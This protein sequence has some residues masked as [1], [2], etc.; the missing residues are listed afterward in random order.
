M[1]RC[2]IFVPHPSGSKFAPPNDWIFS[3][4]NQTRLEGLHKT[5][6][7]IKN[8]VTLRITLLTW[9]IPWKKYF[10]DLLFI[11][12]STK[13]DII[14]TAVLSEIMELY[15][16]ILRDQIHQTNRGRLA[17]AVKQSTNTNGSQRILKRVSGSLTLAG[18]YVIVNSLLPDSLSKW[19][20][21][22]EI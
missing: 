1:L 9:Y 11:I 18:R 15:S 4:S 6:R 10:R 12:S 14:T 19:Q 22:W 13:N 2:W 3:L 20:L 21:W 7:K 17:D 8:G 16:L 5:K